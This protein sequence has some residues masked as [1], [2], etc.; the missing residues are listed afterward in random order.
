[1]PLCSNAQ[2]VR[3]NCPIPI[4]KVVTPHAA[5]RTT[6]TGDTLTLSNITTDSLVAYYVGNTDSGFVT[7]TN[8][9][10]DRGF[11]ERY[12][13]NAND[14]SLKVIGVM[15]RFTGTVNPSSSNKV[16]FKVWHVGNETVIASKL[17]FSGFP[18]YCLD[19]TSAPVTTLGIGRT[20]DTLKSFLFAKPTP[21]F[22]NSFFV[23][24]D[25]DYNYALL[26]GDTIALLSSYNGSR[27]SPNY[28]LRTN[29]SGTD[30]T[31]DTIV[32]VQ[33]ATQY[34]DGYWHDNRFE[35]FKLNHNLAIY[36]IVIVSNPTG[37]ERITRNGLTM[38]ACYPNPAADGTNIRYALSSVDN[39]KL[40]IFDTN[41]RII[42]EQLLDNQLPELHNIY[43][44]TAAYPSG[45]YFYVIETSNGAGIAGQMVVKK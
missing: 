5:M 40:R 14:S 32:N 13:F 42:A 27:T 7:G 19:T 21:A 10:G 16:N 4:N 23:G 9:Y 12:D 35:N 43:V 17:V 11:A 41:G 29:I 30:T 37:N 34:S 18:G 3:Q 6:A 38:F 26:A 31:V 33:N 28:T 36:P 2:S 25:I 22:N 8:Y 15:A 1:M 44:S 45:T 24:Y 20:G 39:V